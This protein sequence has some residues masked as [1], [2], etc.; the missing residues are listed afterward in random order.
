MTAFLVVAYQSPFW[1]PKICICLRSQTCFLGHGF[2]LVCKG[3]AEPGCFCLTSPSACVTMEMVAVPQKTVI[4]ASSSG[5]T[6]MIL[7]AALSL[8][9]EPQ[10]C[11]ETPGTQLLDPSIRPWAPGRASVGSS[12]HSYWVVTA[13]ALEPQVSVT[14]SLQDLWTVKIP[15]SSHPMKWLLKTRETQ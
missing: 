4:S 13:P 8:S 5:W 9:R 14:D 10:N 15:E 6:R 2:I 7:R 1:S 3:E 11:A 12:C